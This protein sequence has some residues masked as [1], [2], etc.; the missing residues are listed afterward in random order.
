MVPAWL[1]KR[2]LIWPKFWNTATNWSG[3]RSAT[4]HLIALG[5]RRIGLV[6]GPKNLLCSRARLDGYRAALESAGIRV[7]RRLIEP[8]DFRHESGFTADRAPTGA[9]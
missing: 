6:E 1:P 7:D 9:A 2:S 4:E 8:G 5:H 3:G